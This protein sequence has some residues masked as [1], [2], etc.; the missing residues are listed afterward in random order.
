MDQDQGL[1]MKKKRE[2][3]DTERGYRQFGGKRVSIYL[4]H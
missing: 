2:Q 3:P 1:I 4:K